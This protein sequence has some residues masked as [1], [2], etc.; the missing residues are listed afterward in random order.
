MVHAGQRRELPALP[1]RCAADP[2]R[3]RAG[4][5]SA[6]T[7]A[8][9]SSSRCR[10]RSCRW[11]RPSTS[12]RQCWIPR[13]SCG[14]RPRLRKPAA[15]RRAAPK[16]VD[17]E[18]DPEFLELFIEEAKDEIAKLK[19]LFPL[20]DENPQDQDSLVN[21]RRSFHTLK[22]SGRMVGA[23]LIGEF[24]WS[25]E[26]L[27][28]RVINKTLERSARHDDAAARSGR[29][30]AGA[31]RAARNRAQP[32]SRR[33]RASSSGLN[34]HRRRAPSAPPRPPRVRQRRVLLQRRCAGAAGA[35][36][37]ADHHGPALRKPVRKKKRRQR[38]T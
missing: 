23:Q 26:N 9:S 1:R 15:K 10:R 14:R 33:R 12:P 24:A 25:V 18:I 6:I 5:E 22:G 20:W 3:R 32:A 31:G 29:G 8:R 21:V 16:P 2:A 27:L 4:A 13:R 35:V 11:R 34:E 36:A 37:H 7:R 38:R 17:R 28:N 19:Q 30:G